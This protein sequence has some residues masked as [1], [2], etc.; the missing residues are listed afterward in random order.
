[1]CSSDLVEGYTYLTALNSGSVDLSLPYMGFYGDWAEAPVLDEEVYHWD[2]INYGAVAS[3]YFHAL[4]TPIGNTETYLGLNAYVDEKMDPAHMV[5]SPDGN[6]YVDGVSDIYVSL[7]RNAAEMTVRYTDANTGEVYYEHVL[8]NAPK[9]CYSSANG[10]VIPFVYSWY[11]MEM[12]DFEGLA[13]NTE[14]RMDL[15]FLG[16]AE[17]ETKETLT[18]NITV[19]TEAPMLQSASLEDGILTLTF[20]ENVSTAAVGLLNMDGTQVYE[21]V[22]VED[23]AENAEGYQVNTVSFDASELTGKVM[24]ALC[25]YGLNERYY[26][27]NMGGEGASYG[28]MVAYQYNF[29][30]GTNGWVSFGADVDMDET[31]IFA[32]ETDFVCAEYVN[33]YIFAQ[34][35]DG[36]FYGIRYEDMLS[37]TMVLEDTYITTLDNVYQDLTY[38]YFDGKLYGLVTYEDNYGYPTSEINMINIGDPYYDENLWTNVGAYDEVWILNRGGVYGLTLASDDTGRMYVL[39]TTYDWETEAMGDT[40]HLWTVGFEYDE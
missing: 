26:A 13:N 2:Y 29:Y 28:D 21:L 18:Y 19:D 40:A 27:L 24:V 36:K 34:T 12:Y 9:S 7:M 14:L 20:T 11:A 32:G 6:G 22:G 4:L 37:N 16:V 1:M 8:Q 15:E 31:I 10:M 33:G 3:Q 23:V 38:N 39:G 17:G 25:D 35:E 30:T 5:I